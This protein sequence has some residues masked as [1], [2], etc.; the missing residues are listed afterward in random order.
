MTMKRFKVYQGSKLIDQVFYNDSY[1]AVD[2]KIS[3][4]DHDGYDP[5]IR[6][7]STRRTQSEKNVIIADHIKDMF[8]GYDDI[9]E[10]ALY[11]QFNYMH[12]TR[13]GAINLKTI[14]NDFICGGC[15]LIY[16]GDIEEFLQALNVKY[17]KSDML[18]DVYAAVLFPVFRKLYLSG[19]KL[20]GGSN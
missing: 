16:D 12:D 9:L 5:N 6:V 2:V 7:T 4:V 14:V 3:L 15:G 13:R 10:V 11:K 19:K 1:K 18:L 17:K 20:Q 8:D